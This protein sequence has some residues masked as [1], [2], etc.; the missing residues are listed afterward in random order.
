[1]V[2]DDMFPNGGQ[3]NF[4]FDEDGPIDPVS[5]LP[6]GGAPVSHSL[7]DDSQQLDSRGTGPWNRGV[8]E[9]SAALQLGGTTPAPAS[10]RARA[11]LTGNVSDQPG[12][13][14]A[15]AF[16]EAFA[17]DL[18]E[19]LGTTPTTLSITFTLTGKI[20]NAP[21]DP[22]QQ[23]VIASQIAVFA[24]TNYEFTSDLGQL[25]FNG[26]SVVLTYDDSTLRRTADTAGGTFTLTKT[27]SFTASP[28]DQFYVWQVLRAWAA[29]DARSADA[30]STLSASFDQP[31]LVRSLAVP[32]PA[33]VVLLALAA[34]ALLALRRKRPPA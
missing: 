24:P 33:Q 21:P 15:A 4:S 1:V 7:I 23:T 26:T 22:S 16:T 8:A 17:S 14:D 27:L 13:S 3:N 25:R 6:E 29:G 18:F 9:A 32:E 28:G 31:Q 20:A 19:F 12:V 34:A 30:Y 2:L 5:A 10:L 11:V